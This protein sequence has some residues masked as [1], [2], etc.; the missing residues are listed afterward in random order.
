[1]TPT[2]ARPA[3]RWVPA[4][5]LPVRPTLDAGSPAGRVA[6]LVPGAALLLVVSLAG[7]VLAAAGHPGGALVSAVVAA[8]LAGGLLG[9][10]LVVRRDLAGAYAA[11][12]ALQEAN[13]HLERQAAELL[14]SNRDLE[15]FAYAASHDLQEPL[16]KVA[17]FCQ[18]LQRRYAGRLDE[19]ADQYIA[20]AVDGAQRMQRLI[21]DLLAF[22]RIGRVAATT[23]VDLARVASGV[24]AQHQPQV[25]AAGG[26]I[27]WTGLP[28]VR[29]EEALLQALLGN[30]VGNSV[31]FA[32][33]GTPPRVELSARRDGDYWEITCADNGIGIEPGSAE[34]AFVIF[35][36]LHGKEAY[37]G[38]GIGLAVA[39]KIVE[40][41]GGRIWIDG[42]AG[43]G[44]TIRFTLPANAAANPVSPAA[45]RPAEEPVA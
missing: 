25:E 2:T 28:T 44:T 31:K 35:Q 22:S 27:T 1:M 12:R 20:F 9:L 16:R 30:L 6:A 41:H 19:R 36:R 40:Y 3:A 32:R 4:R 29:G 7:T 24:A 15:Q 13:E 33:E 43:A 5:W 45:P 34:K 39:K 42:S 11:L 26:A 18:L 23:D 14:R 38:T 21:N 37:P 17:S 10:A 8:V